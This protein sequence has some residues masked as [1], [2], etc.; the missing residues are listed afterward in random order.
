MK[1][2]NSLCQLELWAAECAMNIFRRASRPDRGVMKWPPRVNSTSSY[3]QRMTESIPLKQRR[4]L[5]LND[6]LSPTLIWVVHCL[7][8]YFQTRTHVCTVASIHDIY[9]QQ[10]LY[11]ELQLWRPPHSHHCKSKYLPGQFKDCLLNQCLQ[12]ET[13]KKPWS[14]HCKL[15]V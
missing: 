7:L 11:R 4:Q 8:K 2:Q 10:S 5:H 9:K 14:L 13:E 3:Q 15:H 1:L 6:T 12:K